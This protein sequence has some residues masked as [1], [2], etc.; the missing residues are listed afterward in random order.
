MQKLSGLQSD[1]YV[2]GLAGLDKLGGDEV[3]RQSLFATTPAPDDKPQR[4]HK[5]RG[6]TVRHDKNVD[7]TQQQKNFSTTSATAVRN[8]AAHGKN[9]R[10]CAAS[11]P[12]SP[13]VSLEIFLLRASE[14]EQVAG[15]SAGERLVMQNKNMLSVYG[16]S[17]EGGGGG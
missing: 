17:G 16:V 1:A 8:S 14:K 12:Q 6:G 13:A 2:R 5:P 11:V 4:I 10:V 15:G 9:A 7:S 3:N